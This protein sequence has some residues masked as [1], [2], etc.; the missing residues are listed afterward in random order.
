MVAKSTKQMEKHKRKIESFSLLCPSPAIQSLPIMLT[1]TATTITIKKNKGGDET[2][3]IHPPQRR[4][5]SST[6]LA[7]LDQNLHHRSSTLSNPRHLTTTTSYLP[8]HLQIQ[9][10]SEPATPAILQGSTLQQSP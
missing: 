5:C 7:T 1:P 10:S 9:T 3:K 2:T 6:M 4:R 8:S